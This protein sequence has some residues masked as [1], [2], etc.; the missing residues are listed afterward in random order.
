MATVR[1]VLERKASHVLTVGPAATVLQAALVM[2]EHRVGALVAV[3]DGR[4][5]G[6]F[7]ERDVLQRV[8]AG[9]RDPGATRVGEMMTAPMYAGALRLRA[10]RRR[11]GRPGG[12]EVGPAVRPAGRMDPAPG[13][14][15]GVHHL[16]AIRGEPAAHGRE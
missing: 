8:V 2:N 7:T 13:P 1:E 12:R 3:E 5:V 11:P 10:V 15:A 4:M 14:S 9:W 16:G 6:M